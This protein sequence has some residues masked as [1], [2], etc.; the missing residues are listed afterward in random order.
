MFFV[1]S[2]MRASC[3]LVPVAGFALCIVCA[4]VVAA[5]VEA[6]ADAL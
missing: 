6:A 5:A 1:V 3:L 4:V 2:S